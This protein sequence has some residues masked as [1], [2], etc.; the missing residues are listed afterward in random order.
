MKVDGL[1][2]KCTAQNPKVDGGYSHIVVDKQESHHWQWSVQL[3]YIVRFLV[4]PN[5]L[6]N[7][8]CLIKARWWAT[9]LFQIEWHMP[10][11]WEICHVEQ[12][13]KWTCYFWNRH[14]AREKKSKAH[15]HLQI[16]AMLRSGLFRKTRSMTVP[17]S[18]VLR[19]SPYRVS[20]FQFSCNSIF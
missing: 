7:N 6:K 3:W 16:D 10:I 11:W 13:Y 18:R 5:K 17:G 9:T 14:R 15:K 19:K 12:K 2:L 1:E 4:F 20:H 8:N